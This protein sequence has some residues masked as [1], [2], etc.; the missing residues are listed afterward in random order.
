LDSLGVVHTPLDKINKSGQAWLASLDSSS[1]SKAWEGAAI[2]M[3][4]CISQADFDKGMQSIRAP[5][6]KMESRDIRS[7]RH[8][9][10][11]PGLPV[12]DYWVTS[13]I[14]KFENKPNVAENVV[15][16]LE[17]D[18]NWRVAGYSLPDA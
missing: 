7:L 1:Y 15:L 14:T 9:T 18:G 8:H 16:A 11:L 2:T 12:G 6:G 5:L 17:Q 3:R 4:S 10:H 13:Y